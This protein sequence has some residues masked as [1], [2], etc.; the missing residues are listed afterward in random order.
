MC[1]QAS[2]LNGS[3]KQQENFTAAFSSSPGAAFN[4]VRTTA[5]CIY[6]VRVLGICDGITPEYQHTKAVTEQQ[7][8]YRARRTS[9]TRRLL[10]ATNKPRPLGPFDAIP[11]TSLGPV[12]IIRITNEKEA[13]GPLMA[14]ARVGRKR[15]GGNEGIDRRAE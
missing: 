14:S 12:R 15:D 8:L 10:P 3:R 11:H 13:V 7:Q 9:T 1:E 4:Q 5:N 2:T 6:C